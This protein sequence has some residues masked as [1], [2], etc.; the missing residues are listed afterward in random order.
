MR[1]FQVP[2]RLTLKPLSIT[3]Y[4][5]L[6]AAAVLPCAL[7]CLAVEQHAGRKA[8]RTCCQRNMCPTVR[9]KAHKHSRQVQSTVLFTSHPDT[10]ASAITPIPN[11]IHPAHPI[12]IVALKVSGAAYL[13]HVA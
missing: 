4:A 3:S 6:D 7:Y 10:K 9:Q 2:H 12:V 1:V 13:P 11:S 5:T 8:L